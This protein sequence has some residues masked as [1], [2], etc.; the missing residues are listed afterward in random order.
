MKSASEDNKIQIRVSGEKA[1][2]S[3]DSVSGPVII[4]IAGRSCS[5]KSTAITELEEKYKGKILHII[6]DKFFKKAGLDEEKP[7]SLMLEKF[8]NSLNKLKNGESALI[9]SEPETEVFDSEVRPCRIIIAEGHLLFADKKVS[10]LFDKKIWVDVTDSNLLH[11]RIVRGGFGS[12]PDYIMNS[13]IPKSKRYEQLQRERADVIIDGN[14]PKGQV[15]EEI[16]KLLKEWN[17][18]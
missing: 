13:V 8:R 16:E 7:E 17:L 9:P 4:G 15:K 1:G 10:D 2:S 11:R 12:D 14:N 5:G 18:L 3:V 6:L